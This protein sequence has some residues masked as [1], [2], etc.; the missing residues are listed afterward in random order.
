MSE[1]KR[2]TGARE[3]AQ[4]LQQEAIKKA[5]IDNTDYAVAVAAGVADLTETITELVAQVAE[6]A[7]KVEA[8]EK[9]KGV[10]NYV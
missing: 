3:R 5:S 10:I 6:L 8:L 2:R 4:I 1:F 7:A 9:G